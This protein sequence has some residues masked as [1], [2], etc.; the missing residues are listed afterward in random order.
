MILSPLPKLPNNMGDLGK[1]IVATGFEKLPKVL[2]IAS[3]G[4]TGWNTYQIR[5]LT[6]GE[7]C[8]ECKMN[9]SKLRIRYFTADMFLFFNFVIFCSKM[10]FNITRLIHPSWQQQQKLSTSF[11][12]NKI[13]LDKFFQFFLQS[14][15][16]PLKS[17][18]WL[19]TMRN[20]YVS[21]FDDV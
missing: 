17:F 15:H 2:K 11:D 1:T 8:N 21:G 7:A 16:L 12:N 4:N 9:G 6:V 18:C 5:Y 19:R 3:S 13:V 20:V 10:T 14:I